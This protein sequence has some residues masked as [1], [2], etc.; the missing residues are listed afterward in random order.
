MQQL[1]VWRHAKAVPWTPGCEDF[2][3][4]LREVGTRHADNIAR[5]MAEHVE[6]PTCILCSPSQRTRET[7]APLLAAQPALEQVTRFIPQI[8]HATA[9]TLE[10]MLDAAFAESDR[11]LVVGHNPGL[12]VLVGDTVHRRHLEEYRRLPTGTLAVI[13]FASGWAND[14]GQG[15]LAHLVRGKSLSVD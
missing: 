15:R 10:T 9:G 5:W 2:S 12:E 3:R 1:M 11:V 13:D 6:D 8:Y 4:Q 7:L 14:Q